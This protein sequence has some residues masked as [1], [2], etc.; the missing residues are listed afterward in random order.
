MSYEPSSLVL[1]L[2]SLRHVNYNLA[3]VNSTFN[4][5][6]KEYA[7][8]I[9]MFAAPFVAIGVCFFLFFLIYSFFRGCCKCC[10]RDD[11]SKGAGCFKKTLFLLAALAVLLGAAAGLDGSVQTTGAAEVTA[12]EI[13]SAS[14]TVGS[15]VTIGNKLAG[16]GKQARV[17]VDALLKKGGSRLPP[18]AQQLNE[19]VSRFSSVVSSFTQSVDKLPQQIDSVAPLVTHGNAI[20]AD[21]NVAFVS[22]LVLL[23]LLS[24]L[25]GACSSVWLM[26]LLTVAGIAVIL[27]AWVFVGFQASLS[28]L[29]ADFCFAPNA[30]IKASVPRQYGPV[31]AY[32][33]DCTGVN[34]LT[35]DINNST[36][37]LNETTAQLDSLAAFNRQAQLGL[38]AEINATAADVAAAQQ[39]I[40]DVTH[41]LYCKSLNDDYVALRSALC[42]TAMHAMVQQFFGWLIA[43]VG[44]VL[45]LPLTWSFIEDRRNKKKPET[46]A[47]GEPLLPSGA[48]DYYG[49]L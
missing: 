8:S 6:S 13:S 34:P 48:D 49:K 29:T 30:L 4:P 32:Y 44:L 15:A 31:V 33:V 19:S 5:Y 37:A 35:R 28:V 23:C 16:I 1:T 14:K 10:V 41:V 2:H 38:G 20:R 17:D 18:S 25:T 46:I 47:L 43:A 24:C 12:H 22:L 9:G 36:A 42:Q 11:D 3:A 7:T 39:T 27:L 40:P 26:L 21:A 45:L